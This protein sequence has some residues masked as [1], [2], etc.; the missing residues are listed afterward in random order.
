MS[1][2]PSDQTILREG[3]TFHFMPGLWMKDWGIETTESIIITQEG[4]QT[5][6]DLPRQLFVKH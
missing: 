6:C 4:A 3:M 1:L 5:L 2:R